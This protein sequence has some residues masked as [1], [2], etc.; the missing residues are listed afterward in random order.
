MEKQNFYIC[1]HCGNIA[2]LVISSGVPLVCCGEK[3]SVITP[4]TTDASQEKH[5]PV[6]IKEGDKLVVKVGEVPHP[7]E[8]KHFIQF[9]YVQTKNGGQK[10]N[11][12][13]SDEPT[14]TFSFVNDEPIAVYEYCNLHGL[15]VK[16]I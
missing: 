13:P 6:A 11:L 16:E 5:V 3:M 8:E 12:S 2:V 9:I 14:A 1:K 7:M 15:W 4:N 10:K